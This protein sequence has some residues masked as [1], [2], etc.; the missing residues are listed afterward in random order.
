MDWIGLPEN[1]NEEEHFAFV[2]R[3]TNIDTGMKYIGKK[4][5]FSYTKRPP[6]KNK[7][8]KRSVV[9]PSDYLEYYGSSEDLKKDL[10]KYGKDKFKREVLEL[11]SCKW[12][13]AWQE[14][15]WQ[16]KE[17]VLFRDDYHNGIINIRLG[18]P[19]KHLK[20]KYRITY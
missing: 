16:I 13:A 6:L 4:Q 5:F 14:M 15:M 2:Y 10:I 17:N 7:K 9:K 20:E 8:R 12:E 11:C 1:I 19:P 18:R 3:I